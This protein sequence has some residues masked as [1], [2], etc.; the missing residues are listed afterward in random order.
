MDPQFLLKDEVEFELACRGFTKPG[1]LV[2]AL[3][4]IL[5]KMM[6]AENLLQ[7]SYE[8]KPPPSCLATPSIELGICS[9]KISNI[10][11]YIS[12]L[13]EK[14]DKQLYKRLVSRLV[15]IVNRLKFIAPIEEIDREKKKALLDKAI[16]LL[17]DL[18]DKDD[19]EDGDNI[20]PEMKEA[21]Q[22]SLGEDSKIILN[23]IAE[24]A[25]SSGNV[26]STSKDNTVGEDFLL[27]KQHFG[28]KRVSFAQDELDIQTFPSP[29]NFNKLLNSTSADEGNYTRKLKLVPISQ[30][31]VQFSGDNSFS[32]NAFLERVDELKDARNATDDDL[33]RHAIDFFRDSGASRTVVNSEFADT[34]RRLGVSAHRLKSFSMAT[35]DGT[36][37]SITKL[38]DVPVQFNNQFHIM[39]MLLMP[40]LSQPL[41]LGKDF[42][43]LFGISFKF[44]DN[45]SQRQRIHAI[46]EETS[47]I[48]CK[49]DL[50]KDEHE[51]LTAI[52]N[53]IRDNI[54]TGLGRTTI[55]RHTIDTGTNKPIYQKQY[56]F[57]PVIKKQ[58][59][60]ELDDMLSK[61]VVEPSHS[62]WCSPIVLVKKADGTNRLCLDSR[63]LNKV[64]KR[65][66]Y[67]LPRLEDSSKEKT[68]FAV[69]G[70][71]LFHFKV[72]PFG[73][74]NA[75]QTQQRLMDMLFHVLDGKVWA[76]LDDIVVC[77][78]TFDE[79]LI[80]LKQVMNILKNAGLTINVEKCKFARSS[81]RF[82]GYI[83]DKDGLRTD[84]D[85][86]TAILNFP[87]PKNLTELKRFIGIASWYRRFVKNFSIVAAPLHNLTKGKKNK[88]FCWNDEA[89]KAF[90]KL[91]TLLTSTPVISCP[92]FTKPFVIQ[93]DASTKGI[94]AVLCQIIN[95][96]ERPIAYLSRKLNDREQLY[97]TSERELLSIVFAIEKF[98]PYIEGV[99]FTVIT[100]HSALKM[101]H[102]MKDPHGRLARWAM[103]LQ[104]FSFDVVHKPG[105]GLES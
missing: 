27:Q 12:E 69:P 4:K 76:Y 21:L 54:G 50:N 22:N 74:V 24:D 88:R 59:E 29:N 48:I 26:P 92:D 45:A 8:I 80:I 35:A 62:P 94:G 95:K 15:H 103:K 16:I 28:H 1:S 46:S 37:H 20:T 56:N 97:S 85:K 36:N 66:T 105:L 61:D 99:S 3:K 2:S 101:L 42:F 63:Q 41:I 9:D 91:K 102:K 49:E 60:R 39:S 77:S 81:L 89:E 90:L 78:E 64:T 19:I 40:N 82:L 104:Q 34:L 13:Q 7:V 14:P 100:D 23:V 87:R 67:P 72:M 17:K 52:I 83:V 53:E 86:V 44:Q 31:G 33:W 5:K 96:E 84:P 58:I 65:D 11:C 71:G 79:H 73:L 57:S 32:V 43:D 75:S 51:R 25:P 93:C 30:W 70:R 38:Y 18:E 68:A 6:H 55:L 10:L 98:R 47:A